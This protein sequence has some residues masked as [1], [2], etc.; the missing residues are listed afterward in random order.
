MALKSTTFFITILTLILNPLAWV[1]DWL[2]KRDIIKYLVEN[3][4]NINQFSNIE[5]LLVNIPLSTIATAFVTIATAYV[6]GQKGKTISANAGK[7]QGVGL[8]ENDKDDT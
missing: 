3:N 1:A 4:V 7:P 8:K 6:A 5:K 2:L